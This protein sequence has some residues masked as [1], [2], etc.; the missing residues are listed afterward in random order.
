MDIS[1]FIP[2]YP[3]INDKKFSYK[4]A[5]KKE[6]YDLR[7]EPQEEVPK[8]AGEPLK[9]QEIIRRFFSENTDYSSSLLYHGMGTG[10]CI[11]PNTMVYTTKGKIRA[12]ELWYKNFSS[13]ISDGEGEWSRP[14]Y[15]IK[16]WS[17]HNGKPIETIVNNLYRQWVE[18][19]LVK[20]VLKDSS[21]IIITKAHR[22]YDGIRWTNI[23]DIGDS[24]TTFSSLSK[25]SS[26]KIETIEYIS[27]E[28]WVYDFEISIHHN[29]I[30]NDILCHNTCSSALVAE[31][32]KQTLVDGKPRKRALILVKNIDLLR[33][34]EEDISKVCT[35]DIYNIEISDEEILKRNQSKELRTSKEQL[36]HLKRVRLSKLLRKTYEIWTW[37]VFLKYV[38][39]KGPFWTK[40]MYSNRIVIID[41]A[42]NFSVSKSIETSSEERKT[43]KQ[44]GETYS[45]IYNF[46]HTIEN[47]RVILLSGTPIW[48]QT[49]EIAS[50]LNLILP[51]DQK[52]EMGKKFLE[53]Y[54]KDN[55][56][57]KEG[58]EE[59]KER[60]RGR[61]SYIRPMT[62]TQRD[63]IGVTHP[64]LEHIKVYP[65]AMSVFQFQKAQEKFKPAKKALAKEVRKER[66]FLHSARESANMVLPI[67]D[68][69]KSKMTD[70]E[71]FEY[72]VTKTGKSYTLN[73]G[74]EKD[75]NKKERQAKLRQDLRTNLKKYST[76]FASIIQKIRENP[77]ELIFIYIDNFIMGPGGG[78]MFAMILDILQKDGKK[79]FSWAKSSS[80]I[81]RPREDIRRFAI[82]SSL[83]GT[84]RDPPEIEKFL[85]SFNEPDNR[86]GDRCQIIIGSQK[87]GEGITIKNVRQAHILV[88]HWNIPKIEQ[89][90]GR[91]YRVNSHKALPE[92]ERKL[93][94][95]RHVAVKGAKNK[96]EEIGKGFP[97]DYGFSD[98]ET[99]DIH[100][101]R[102]AERKEFRNVQIQRL[103]KEIAWDCPLNYKRNVL[104]MDKSDTKPCDYQECNYECDG[105][106]PSSK[107]G[108][109]WK[110]NI[111]EDKIQKDTYNLYY[112][113]S[114]VKEIVKEIIQLFGSYFSLPF[115]LIPKL[116]SLDSKDEPLLLIALDEIINS[117]KIIRNRFG[118]SSYLKEENNIYFLDNHVSGEYTYSSS[119]YTKYPIV[120][121][122]TSLKVISEISQLKEDKRDVIRFCKTGDIKIFDQL[123]HI[124]Q[125]I[126]LEYMYDL[127]YKFER[128]EIELNELEKKV[129]NSLDTKK[130]LEKKFFTMKDGTIIHTLYDEKVAIE[131]TGNKKIYDPETGKW[132][133][134]V[135]RAREKK[136][137]EE[138]KESISKRQDPWINNPYEVVAFTVGDDPRIRILKKEKGFTGRICNFF[139]KEDILSIAFRI[140]LIFDEET[141]NLQS[142]KNRNKLLDEIKGHQFY[143]LYKSYKETLE[144]GKTI[145]NTEVEKLT[146]KELQ[147]LLTLFVLSNP[148]LCEELKKWFKNH[149]LFYLNKPI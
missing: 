120:T 147:K 21:S 98:T 5:K 40:A 91:V 30:A 95:Y 34:F 138:I 109:I 110:Y 2:S 54:F 94:I 97:K 31:N 112:S 130:Y 14:I 135:D 103:L 69:S 77:N 23:F 141:L 122:F 80:D 86:Y 18:E 66:A 148:K 83:E 46:L 124:T 60:F 61:I 1:D 106:P 146:D 117:R 19:D 99:L 125:I 96:G 6:F 11:H 72:Y 128:R 73:P 126:I 145:K 131:V 143:P 16:L 85:K 88:P 115:S 127:K 104:E 50:L 78:M 76:K 51:E 105:F 102:I 59:L 64:W 45:K 8:G 58:E 26:S 7:L 37:E 101:Y 70:K 25:F 87:I 22:L 41:E 123:S 82:L 129:I 149:D 56:L 15:I 55:I 27:Y 48:D 39:E 121:E 111:P 9:H 89:A 116:I 32:F 137:V 52:L 134:L 119:S 63:E 24:I 113:F 133:Y 67:Y 12:E 49:S 20:I 57:T 28:G 38:S 44:I 107:K 118:F 4:L 53:K 47:S 84:I 65:D 142:K 43:K 108:K 71:I 139:R 10:K 144:S 100:V 42:H 35:K 81:R 136:Y 114:K 68:T 13:I 79:E 93:N 3:D 75:K 62:S 140:K 29:Y 74:F 132:E 33:N 90:L 92:N 36:E 17:Y